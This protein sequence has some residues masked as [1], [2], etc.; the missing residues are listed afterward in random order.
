MA[1]VG[2]VLDVRQPVGSYGLDD[3]KVALSVPYAFW[4]LGAVQILRYR[5][6]AV[7]HLRRLH[8]GVVEALKRGE[9][10]SHPGIGDREGI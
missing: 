10:F 5:R 8:P 2:V 7:A 3:F 4:L 6:K 1:L 9:H